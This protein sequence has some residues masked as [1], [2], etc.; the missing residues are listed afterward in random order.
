MLSRNGG[1][2][3]W[4]IVEVSLSSIVSTVV[5]SVGVESKE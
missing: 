2:G 1:L 3:V 4:G 5:V